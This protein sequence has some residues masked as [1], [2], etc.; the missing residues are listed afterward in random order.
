MSKKIANTVEDHEIKVFGRVKGVKAP[1]VRAINKSLI[2]LHRSISKQQHDRIALMT[3]QNK[4]RQELFA[5]IFNILK[6]DSRT[7]DFEK[8]LNRSHEKMREVISA[9]QNA[10]MHGSPIF[11]DTIID[12]ASPTQFLV[13]A[14]YDFEAAYETNGHSTS[15]EQGYLD[16]SMMPF[17]ED[18]A[19]AWAGVGFPLIPDQDR[20]YRVQPVFWCNYGAALSGLW[21]F[22]AHVEMSVKIHVHR[23]DGDW[24]DTEEMTDYP[25]Q[26]FTHTTETSYHQ[27][28][29]DD[30]QDPVFFVPLRGDSNY[31][32][33]AAIELAGNCTP[34][35]S[36]FGGFFRARC[37][38]IAVNRPGVF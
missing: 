9:L 6:S 16:A 8:T 30:L 1:P 29:S 34:S 7:R 12:D 4:L 18:S 5:P 24:Q 21:G 31:L 2:G 36:S 26:I 10:P 11:A 35:Y 22:T 28:V 20:T 19:W 25:R 23:Y 37:L 38:D 27:K 17:W 3:E 14:P 32:I 15:D 33:W 13:V